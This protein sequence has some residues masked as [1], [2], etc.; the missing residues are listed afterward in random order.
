MTDYTETFN[1]VP[2]D[3]PE[4]KTRVTNDYYPTPHEITMILLDKI[5]GL[6]EPFD[7]VFDPCAGH[8]AILESIHMKQEIIAIANEPYINPPD[9]VEWWKTTA[10]TETVW[11]CVE[12]KLKT[13]FGGS[14]DWVITNPPYDKELMLPI[15]E[16]SLNYARKGFATLVRLSWLEPCNGRAE[17]L[18]ANADQLRYVIPVSPRPK[19]RADTK[20]S[21]N[22]TSCWMVWDKSWSWFKAGVDCPFVFASGWKK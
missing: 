14:I 12:T 1:Y 3:K 2:S 6:I 18:Q 5:G 13:D 15:M 19:F 17:F 21:D 16:H 11:R 22:V 10:C 7:V 8:G 20:G 4:A 9:G